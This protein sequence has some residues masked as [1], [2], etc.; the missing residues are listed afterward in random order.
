MCGRQVVQ[1]PNVLN[2]SVKRRERGII[3]DLKAI[4][5]AMLVVIFDNGL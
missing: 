4:G 1:K 3:Y 2:W 5:G